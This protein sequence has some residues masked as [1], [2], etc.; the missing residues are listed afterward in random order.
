[1]KKAILEDADLSEG[2]FVEVNFESAGLDR[3]NLNGANLAGANLS[4]ALLRGATLRNSNLTSAKLSGAH[5]DSADLTEAN[6]LAADLR[7]AFLRGTRFRGARVY[8][9]DLRGARFEPEDLPE[10]NSLATAKNLSQTNWYFSPQGL[11]KLRNA[12][13]DAGYRSQEREVTYAIKHSELLGTDLTRDD[14]VG[15]RVDRTFRYIF[16]ELTTRWGME[17][18]RAL[19][20]LLGL[21]PVFALPYVVALRSPGKNGIWRVW[22]EKRIRQDLGGTQPERL[23][24]GWLTALP[25]GLYF[26]L[27]SA[28][29]IGW[30]ELNVGSWIQR[31]QSSEYT[32]GAT[33]WVRTVSGIQSLLSVYL[34][35]IWALTYFGR[36]FD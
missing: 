25:L 28:F 8:N 22:T 36:P 1:L 21:I 30:R 35:A 3:S 13:K 2:Y 24:V 32:L 29:H 4:N 7:D 20:L 12:F 6:L 27:L 31:L 5:L 19:W 18:G 23:Q 34:L 17:P 33:G 15:G 16:F 14:G 11:V 10:I 26:S 9:V